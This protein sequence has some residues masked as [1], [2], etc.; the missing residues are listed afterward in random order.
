MICPANAVLL[1]P[2]KFGDVRQNGRRVKRSEVA[3]T[4]YDGSPTRR[5]RRQPLRWGLARTVIP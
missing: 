5:A 4:R 1:I 2:A 3:D